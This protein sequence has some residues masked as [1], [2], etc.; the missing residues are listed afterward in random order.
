[1]HILEYSAIVAVDMEGKIW[2]IIHKPDGTQMC[3]H[4]AQGVTYVC[5]AD[6]HNMSWLLVLILEDYGTDNW[7]LK[8]VV[9]MEELFGRINIKVGSKLCDVE[10]RVITVHP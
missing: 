2:R 3:I 4:Q 9:D 10:Y 6:F 5:S 8:H 1:M 7:S